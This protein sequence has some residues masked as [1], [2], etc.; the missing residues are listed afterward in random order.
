MTTFDPATLTLYL[1]ADPDYAVSD[2]SPMVE[3]AIDR[4]VTCLQLRWKLGTDRQIVELARKLRVVC[5][6]ARVP[7]IINDRVDI[8]LA[9]GA[10]GVHL[11]IGDLPVNDARR[12]GG[13]NFIIGYSPESD[14]DI[15]SAEIAGATYLGIG[16]MF[17]T[18]T[19][20][21]AGDVLGPV[22]F[23]RRRS[24]TSLPVVAIGGINASNASVPMTAGA[25]G[26]AVV[27]AILGSDDPGH[28]AQ[29]L[30]RLIHDRP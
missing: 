16:P 14:T 25:N 21:D 5:T 1:I 4:G 28:A 27:S 3:A 11:G 2:I 22:E 9:I 8:A 24:L 18:S 15:A 7:L 26:I 6:T 12:L 29:T 13:S 17:A 20:S 30:R 19:K 23:A 10:D